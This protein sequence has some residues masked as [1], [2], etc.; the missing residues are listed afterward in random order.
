MEALLLYFPPNLAPS[1]KF[2]YTVFRQ[3]HCLVKE[4]MMEIKFLSEKKYWAEYRRLERAAYRAEGKYKYWNDEQH[5]RPWNSPEY[6]YA[7][8]AVDN[9]WHK[10]IDA[11]N[12]LY[13]FEANTR[14]AKWTA[15]KFWWRQIALS[16]E[17][18]T[19]STAHLRKIMK[20]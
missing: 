18:E 20:E 3:Q 1:L 12:A 9:W 6:K 8:K 16:M 15:T 2:W 5:S 4:I 11:G 17:L 19:V 14:I 10:S 7:L 13:Y